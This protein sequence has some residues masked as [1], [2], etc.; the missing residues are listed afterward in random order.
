LFLAQHLGGEGLPTPTDPTQEEIS[1][2]VQKA[3][4]HSSIVLGTYNGHIKQGQLA[5]ALALAQT[6]L[7]LICV[8]LR[9]PYDLRNL[10]KSVYTLAVFEYDRNSLIAVADVLS[11]KLNPTGKLSVTL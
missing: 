9:N 10:P 11:G 4:G 2:L 6:G 7:P 1:A 8:A 5:L 3:Q